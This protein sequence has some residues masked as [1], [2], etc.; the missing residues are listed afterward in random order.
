MFH[1]RQQGQSE[2]VDHYAQ[3]LRKLFYKAYPR[4][5]QDN[6]EAEGFGR[7]VLAYQFVVGLTPVLRTK[8]AGVEGSLEHLLV[9]ARF[10]EAKIR[11]LVSSP[12]GEPNSP[13]WTLIIIEGVIPVLGRKWT[14]TTNPAGA[15]W[16]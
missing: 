11:D 4:A 15:S 13:P 9:K 3:E 16:C 7:A 6:G 14:A 10:K 8:V 5:G 12:S 2:T 1:Q